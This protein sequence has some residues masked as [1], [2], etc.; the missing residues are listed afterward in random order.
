MEEIYQNENIFKKLY[1]N[2]ENSKYTSC[3]ISDFIDSN[4]LNNEKDL[5]S[6]GDNKTNKLVDIMRNR[7]RIVK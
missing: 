2:K 4:T 1:S 6:L 5:F 7:S 3:V